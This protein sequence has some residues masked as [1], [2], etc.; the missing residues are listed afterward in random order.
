MSLSAEPALPLTVK[1][2]LYRIVE[3]SLQ[4]V[5]EHAHAGRVE[6][7]LDCAERDIVLEVRDNGVG[8]DQVEVSP[9][10]LGLKSMHERVTRLGGTMQIDTAPGAGTSIR[11]S[12][13]SGHFEPHD[14][15]L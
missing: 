1:E 12:I 6:V 10:C 11:V 4:N 9:N 13:P 14:S 3:Q 15:D 2:A 8:F 5:I 7:R